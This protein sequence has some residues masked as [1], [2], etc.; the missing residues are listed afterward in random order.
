MA[1]SKQIKLRAIPEYA[2]AA[3]IITALR[4]L[5]LD[6]ANQLSRQIAALLD[7]LL[8]RLRRTAMSNLSFAYPELTAEQR[9]RITDGV[10]RSLGRLLVAVARFPSIDKSNVA[11]WIDYE[12]LEN[13]SAAKT[14]GKGILIATAHLGNW[15]LSAFAHAVM[16]EPMNVMVRPLDNPFIDRLVAMRRMLS[17]NQLIEKKDA[18]R[19]VLRAL[20][21][22]QA[23]GILVDQNTSEAEGM[24]VPFFRRLACAS[25]A[26][27]KLAHHSGAAVI[28]GY[29]VWD[30]SNKRYR[31][32]FEPEIA[33]T[34][35]LG[36][37]LQ[38][39]HY[40]IETAVR[41]YPDQWLWIH[42]R[43]KTRPPEESVTPH[44][45]ST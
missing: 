24:F 6:A 10:F 28:P 12:G 43:W 34:G 29:A 23:V 14:K 20:R 44:N 42:R 26:F 3:L 30:E 32:V 11:D 19:S 1:E 41:K 8:P 45:S 35:D 37:D 13:Y 18:A 5:P 21:K 7:R 36:K 40:A 27:V 31:L 39:V 33:M 17:G 2:L 9:Q 22:N 15:E 16:T 38:A 4:L 25:P